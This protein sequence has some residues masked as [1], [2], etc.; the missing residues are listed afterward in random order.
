[1]DTFYSA[2]EAFEYLGKMI[3]RYPEYVTSPRGQLIHE[4]TSASLRIL[5][6]EH[7]VV[8]TPERKMS[9]KY[10]V[11]E[12]LWYLE[13]KQD[14][15]GS[16]FICKYAKFWDS[17][18]NPDGSLNSNYG[19]Y[20][21]NPMKDVCPQ[22]EMI[23]K[24]RNM[25]QFDYVIDCLMN[26][27]D[28]RQALININ[29]VFHKNIENIKDFPCTTSIQFMIREDRLNM[30]VHMRSCDLVLGFCNDVFQFT[31]IQKLV[32]YALKKKYSQLALGTYTLFA[33]SLHIYERH[34]G[35][36]ES[37][38]NRTEEPNNNFILTYEEPFT[39]EEVIGTIRGHCT[40][41]NDHVIRLKK[42]LGEP[43]C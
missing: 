41:D 25:S 38:I 1:M 11:A 4:Q 26:D 14:K 18:R 40:S 29:S 2:T 31:E 8:L 17:L 21:F 13:A 24:Y 15:E 10:L 20:I 3:Y 22:H 37:I 7:N 30:I 42:T 27:K 28:S 19:Y 33:N 9:E 6:P 16:D 23:E 12:L 35:M 43:L 39:R 34:F 32:L 36:I 5:H